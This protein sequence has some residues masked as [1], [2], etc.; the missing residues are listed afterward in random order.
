[1]T[2]S[3]L[4]NDID[5]ALDLQ[6]YDRFDIQ[7]TQKKIIGVRNDKSST[8]EIHFTNNPQN[9]L[10]VGCVSRHN[11]VRGPV[12]LKNA[13]SK[14]K[15]ETDHFPLFITHEMLADVLHH[16]NKKIESL[17]AKLLDFNKGFKYSFVKEV[18]E[19]ELKAFIG[20]FLYRG[21]YRLNTIRIRKL[22][23]DSYG[24]PMF[25]AVMSSKRFAFILHN[26]SFD[27][28]STRAERWKKDRFT[29]TREFFEKFNNQCMMALAP[30]DYLSL[31]ETLEC[32][33]RSSSSIRVS[34]GGTTFFSNLQMPPDIP[35][36]LFHHHIVGNLQRREDSIIFR[37]P[38]LLFII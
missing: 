6:N 22:F 20:L 30:G 18:S 11:I 17:L 28:E 1:M 35:T 12:G 27:D 25:S 33:Y 10:N 32:R 29:A 21:L 15:T 4:V 31:D 37:T 16:T 14:A 8:K 36:L 7:E 19:M 9:V 38:R 2:K 26:L 24:P 13:A 3:R 23:S 34:R 5:S